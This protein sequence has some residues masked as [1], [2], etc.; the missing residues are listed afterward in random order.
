MLLLLKDHLEVLYTGM[1]THT[2]VDYFT[3][4]NQANPTEIADLFCKG[5][6]GLKTT[7]GTCFSPWGGNRGIW[8]KP[9][10]APT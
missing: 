3:V 5:G 8:R 9:K 1:Y 10:Q 6:L 7:Y 4:F 2:L